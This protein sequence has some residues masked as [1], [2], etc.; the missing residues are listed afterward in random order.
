LTHYQNVCD[1]LY[2][3][4]SIWLARC[5]FSQNDE[6]RVR[7]EKFIITENEELFLGRTKSRTNTKNAKVICFKSQIVIDVE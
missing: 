2:L 6:K 5:K 7:R 3:C 1:A 4:L